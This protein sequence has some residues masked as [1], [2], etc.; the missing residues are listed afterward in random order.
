MDTSRKI[1]T[2]LT[3]ADLSTGNIKSTVKWIE[4]NSNQFYLLDGKKNLWETV[5]ELGKAIEDDN[6]LT[7]MR[8][9][10]NL[11]FD[12]Q[13]VLRAGNEPDVEVK[14][15]AD[16]LAHMGFDENLN[17]ARADYHVIINDDDYLGENTEPANRAVAR[18][19]Q[20]TVFLNI[21]GLD[22]QKKSEIKKALIKE[23][24]RANY[25]TLLEQI[26]SN[27][28]YIEETLRDNKNLSAE[29]VERAQ[30]IV[31]SFEAMFAEFAKAKKR[32]IRIAAMGTKKSGKS[33]VINSLLKRDYAPTSLVLPT[34]NTIKY[35]PDA[36][37]NTITLDYDGK[38]YTFDTEEKIKEFIGNKF[39]EAKKVQACP[40]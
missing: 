28:A 9:A 17:L 30:K 36:K 16:L 25:Q 21:I 40:I 32:P 39:E 4:N 37:D 22:I 8:V 26:E 2:V 33:V 29:S 15:L 19:F 31:A 13:T 24:F 3:E 14:N 38:V 5:E 7:K 1:C 35:I 23:R 12:L 6:T 34:P 20:Q 11:R 27:K 10:Y 18:L